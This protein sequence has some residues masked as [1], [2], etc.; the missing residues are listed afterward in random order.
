MP[1]W[2]T[3]PEAPRNE[4]KPKWGL[5]A[6]SLDTFFYASHGEEQGWEVGPELK[7]AAGSA[8]CGVNTKQEHDGPFTEGSG[9]NEIEIV[10]GP[11]PS[12]T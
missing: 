5:M 10:C 11:F 2:E 6:Q 9:V 8:V 7:C 3:T 4:T 12:W 1:N